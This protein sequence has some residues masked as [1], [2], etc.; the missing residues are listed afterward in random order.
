MG[1]KERFEK[2][3]ICRILSAGFLSK[4]AY[5][6][7]TDKE[8]ENTNNNLSLEDSNSSRLATPSIESYIIQNETRNQE[9][10]ALQNA[11]NSLSPIQREIIYL[12][13]EAKMKPKEIAES[14]G[15][16]YQTVR[17]YWSKAMK[18]LRKKL[19][20]NEVEIINRA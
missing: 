7:Y 6:K 13:F 11:L 8:K 17:N 15:L 5:E 2:G 9:A 12:R 14:I 4:A 10:S 20:S 16:N 18:K 19:I 3:S 1:K